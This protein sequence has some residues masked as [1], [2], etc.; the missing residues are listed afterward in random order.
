MKKRSIILNTIGL[1]LTAI[2]AHGGVT[3]THAQTS[4]EKLQTAELLADMIQKGF[5]KIDGNGKLHIHGSVM[6]IL[7][8]Y[9]GLQDSND[10][11]AMS[12]CQRTG[13]GCRGMD[14]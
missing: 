2:T 10:P 6:D 8:N 1:V 3:V 5:V 13:S 14:E 7:K 4:E 9:Q 12:S 11:K